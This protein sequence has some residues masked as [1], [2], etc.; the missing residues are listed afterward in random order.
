MLPKE[1]TDSLLSQIIFV[2]RVSIYCGYTC[3][4]MPGCDDLL[5]NKIDISLMYGCVDMRNNNFKH[6]FASVN[7]CVQ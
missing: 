7:K 6:M 1:E 5:N 3:N 2:T 4:I